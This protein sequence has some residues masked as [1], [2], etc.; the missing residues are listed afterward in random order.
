MPSGF[1]REFLDKCLN[2]VMPQKVHIYCVRLDIEKKQTFSIY[3]AKFLIKL[4][5][6]FLAQISRS[7]A[8]LALQ[9]SQLK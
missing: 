5:K 1:M 3:M 4:L 7:S 8:D 2:Q 9:S 6:L